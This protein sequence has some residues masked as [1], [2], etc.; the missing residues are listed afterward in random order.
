M[1]AYDYEE[2]HK[3]QNVTRRLLLLSLIFV[4][5][6]GCERYNNERAKLILSKGWV[7]PTQRM[8]PPPLYCYQTIGY[9][10]C[11]SEPLPGQGPRLIS[12]YYPKPPEPIKYCP[13]KITS[14]P[15]ME[16]EIEFSETIF[17]PVPIAGPV[18][19]TP[20]S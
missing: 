12:A 13:P 3:G 10:E 6:T 9:P 18:Q 5:L 11:Y 20:L 16:D 19:I 8:D 1:L 14:Q 4:G 2:Q 7:G 17:E 15:I